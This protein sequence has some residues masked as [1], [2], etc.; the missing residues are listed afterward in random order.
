[1]SARKQKPSLILEQ[2]TKWKRQAAARLLLASRVQAHKIENKLVQGKEKD[3]RGN[4]LWT[5]ITSMH[6]FC[7]YVAGAGLVRKAACGPPTYIYGGAFSSKLHAAMCHSF[8]WPAS[9]R[10]CRRRFSEWMC[11]CCGCGGLMDPLFPPSKQ[12]VQDEKLTVIAYIT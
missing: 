1:M 2:T 5:L 6:F 12:R 8:F 9:S 4:F 10:R 3:C 7:S 11:I